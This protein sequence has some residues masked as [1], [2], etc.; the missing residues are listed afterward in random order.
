MRLK[1]RF[2]YDAE[3]Y[4]FQVSARRKSTGKFEQI[5]TCNSAAV[6]A[7]KKGQIELIKLNPQTEV[8]E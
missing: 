4:C 5:G 1:L 8:S 6:Q 2:K 3:N 7:I